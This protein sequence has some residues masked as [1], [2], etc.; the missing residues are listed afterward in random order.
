MFKRSRFAVAKVSAAVA[1]ALF[2]TVAIAEDNESAKGL[3]VIEVTAQKRVENV[4][5]VP[6]A[7]S[8]FS[9]E[10]IRTIGITEVNDL[11]LFTAG[12]ETNNAT[13]TQTSF[14][15]RGITTNDFGIGLDPAVAVYIDGVYIGRRGASNLNFN[16]VERVEVLKGPQGTLFG[17]NSAAGAIHIITKQAHEDFEGNVRVT[18]GNLGKVKFE[19]IVNAP[20]SD[21]L[22]F[23]GTYINNRRDGFVERIDGGD[24]LGNQK[25]WSATGQLRYVPSSELEAVLR[26]DISKL[27]QDSRPSATLN[28]GYGSGDPFGPVGMDSDPRE[29][30]DV[31][32][33]SLE[34][35]YD[36]GSMM[37]TSISSFREFQR[38][39]RMEDDGSDFDRAHFESELD[40]DQSQWSQELRLTGQYGKLKWTAGATYFYEDIKQTTSINFFTQTLDGFA[41]VRSGLNP[42]IIPNIPPGTGMAGF[43]G[44]LFPQLIGQLVQATGQSPEQ[45][46]GQIAQ[47]NYGKPHRE[48]MDNRNK[49]TSYALYADATYAV[50]D[51][52]DLTVG[53]RYTYDEKDFDIFSEYQN[54][55]EVGFG[56][57]D[58]PFGL[59]FPTPQ[60]VKQSDSWGKLTPRVVL[61]YQWNDQVMTYISYSQGFKAGGFNTLGEAPPVEEE[62]VTN[63]E[64]GVKSTWFDNRLRFNAS[65]YQYEYEN[66]Q[67][68]ELDGPSGGIPSFNLRNVDA[69]GNGIELELQWQATDDLVLAANYSHVDTEY[70][71]WGLFPWEEDELAAGQTVEN[72]VGEAI[73]GMPSDSGY[74]SADY[75]LDVAEGTLKFHVDAT[76]V[77]ERAQEIDL[78][79]M[80]VLPYD[81]ATVE[82]LTADNHIDGY[83]LINA[84]IC[85]QMEEWEVSLYGTNLADENYLLDAGGQANAV[86][87]IVAMPAQPRQYGLEFLYKF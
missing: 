28:P 3:E 79:P 34:V 13:A 32:G 50:T 75:F 30:R 54:V 57:P 69:E 1:V 80:P 60:D 5:E 8:A 42:A 74:V 70:T 37:L 43:Y 33:V 71:K 17:R 36:L 21:N 48:S 24:D 77:S 64:L 58:I 46:L 20:I 68:L 44:S 67:R 85:Y 56:V 39:N 11:G 83:T 2:S 73:S 72:R 82:G 18:L 16:D 22:F 7:I 26:F 65:F 53:L 25:D 49:T 59:A 15:I 63:T 35:N 41:L 23:K 12:L 47:Q 62:T 66:L 45:I 81:P 86:G 29:K 87:A 52:L 55:I 31:A 84:R 40:E 4:Q 10:A 78:D 14:N 38:L 6:I 61:D 9:E 19:T 76:Y 27:D 51:K